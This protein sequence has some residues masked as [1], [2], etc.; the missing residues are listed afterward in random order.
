MKLTFLKAITIISF[1]FVTLAPLNAQTG[2]Y[3]TGVYR[4]LFKEYLNKTDAEINTKVEAA[5][6]QIFHGSSNQQLYYEVGTD[7]AYILDVANNDV[8]SEG[9]S[10]GLMICVQLDKQAEFNKIWKWVK[11]YMQ[12]SSGNL[13]GFFRW[14]LNKDGSAIDNNAAPDGEAYF[15]TALFFAAHRWGN[16]TGIFNY[17]AEAQS[18]IQKVQTGTGGVDLLFNTSSKLITFGVNGDSYNFTDPSYNLPGFF[19]LWAKWSTSNTSFWT[20]TPDAARTL[21]KN[22][23]NSTSGLYADYSNFDGTPKSVSYNSNANRFMYDAWRAVMNLGVDYHWFQKDSWQPTGVTKLLTFFKNQGT[24]YVNHYDWNGGNPGGDHS[25]GLIACNAAACLAVSDKTLATPFVQELWNAGIPTGTY[26][27]YDGMLYLLGLLNCSGN[28]KIYQPVAAGPTVTLTAPTA[29]AS[30]ESP[31]TVTISAT[32]TPLAG[33]T[34]SKVDFYQGTT[35]IGTSTT[36]PY[37]FS[38][39]NVPDGSYSITAIATDNNGASG[40]SSAAI[41]SVAST[42]KIYKTGTAIIIDGTADAVWNDA[43][44]IPVNATKL[45]SGAVTNAADLS[46]SLKALWDNTNLYIYAD[47]NDETLVNE[48]TNAYD[49]DGIELYVDINNDK[50]TTYGANDVQYSFGWNDGTTIGSLPSGRSVTGITYKAIAKTGGYIIEAQIPWSTLQGTPALNQ[51]VGI[52]F[53]INDDDDNGTRDGK[54]SWNAASD[55][56]W[57]DASIFGTGKLMDVLIS[58]PAPTVTSSVN[59]CQNATAT[60]LTATG[61]ALKWY[62]VATAGTALTATPIPST[63]SVGTTTYYVSQT[64][65]GTESARASIAVVVNANPTISAGSTLSVCSGISTVLNA[66]GGSSYTWSNTVNSASTTVSPNMSSTFYVTG[67][68]TAGCY[69]TSSVIVNVNPSPASPT[70]ISPVYYVQNA[71][72]TALYAIGTSL[73]WYSVL[74]GGTALTVAPTP[75]TTTV[76]T[77]YYY[78]SQTVNSC[79]STRAT[80]EVIVE[81]FSNNP[82]SLNIGW[83]FVGCPLTGSTTLQSAL[84]SIWSNVETVKNQDSFYSSANIPALNSLKTVQWGQGY[85]I[86]IT[87]PCTLDWIAR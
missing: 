4:N 26:R 41:I 9:M 42:Y 6:Q 23:S 82:I 63:T 87:A 49:D 73:K 16:G 7:M 13:D 40:T 37:T 5:F 50:A 83:N 25:T 84:S 39:T 17:E 56:A 31:A 51:L 34:I 20:Q 48:S 22:A 71:T 85:L 60:A 43:S 32:V 1:L 8:R 75:I 58:T 78:V 15:I 86:N 12:N 30:F 38:W 14:Q 76:G 54:L 27:Y 67:T 77:T 70:V 55:N 35:K 36:T 81:L 10:Y 19:E 2:A 3:N 72:A 80:I 21:L 59:Y 18:T 29:G 57:Q 64:L 79:E 62:T 46:G 47:V 28:F 24:S 68:N 65:S 52:D 44:V 33:T 74:T 11:T 66:T 45:L 53:M 61:T 69:A